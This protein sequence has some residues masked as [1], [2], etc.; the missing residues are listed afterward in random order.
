MS[1]AVENSVLSR[2]RDNVNPRVVETENG[3]DEGIAYP[4]LVVSFGTPIRAAG[5]H[6]LVNSRNDTKIGSVV[7]RVVSTTAESARQVR[8]KVVYWLEGWS[9]A[10]SGELLL[11][12]GIGTDNATATTKPTRYYQTVGFTYRT[13]LKWVG[14]PPTPEP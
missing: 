2:L 9:P 8:D 10:N 12:M 4:F 6:G 14:L 1:V 11:E 5:D 3:T 13:N 7:V